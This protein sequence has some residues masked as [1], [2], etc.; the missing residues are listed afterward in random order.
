MRTRS[1]GHRPSGSR[2]VSSRH[3]PGDDE[4]PLIEIFTRLLR[5][6]GTSELLGP[7]NSPPETPPPVQRIGKGN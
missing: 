7:P 6:S 2:L 5:L 3:P 4:P 1:S